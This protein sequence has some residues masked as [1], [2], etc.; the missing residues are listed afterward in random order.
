MIAEKNYVKNPL[1]TLESVV[2]QYLAYKR[3]KIGHK[4]AGL[5][6][7]NQISPDTYRTYGIR[8]A[9][10]KKYLKATHSEKIKVV[11]ID[12]PFVNAYH[13]WLN[14]QPIDAS[15][16]TKCVKL[17]TEIHQWAR[18]RGLVKTYHE[19]SFR[20]SGTP[21]TTP[22][23]VTQEEVERI[24]ALDLPP[25]QAKIRDG[26]LLARE[27][28]LHFSDFISLKPEHFSSTQ[29]GRI[30]FEKARTKQESGRNIR[31]ISFVSERALAIWNRYGQKIPIK[32]HPTHYG[33]IIAEIGMAAGLER[34]LIFSHAR[35]SGIFHLIINNCSDHQVKMAAGWTTTKQL[36]RYVNYDRRLLESLVSPGEPRILP[37]PTQPFSHIYK[38]S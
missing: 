13:A 34:K 32:R 38:A 12:T 7:E 10:L 6:S 33:R 9:W 20:G 11:K 31:Q 22:Y 28:C 1:L 26:W 27:L 8:W 35:D 18:V 36:T 19:L 16:A 24:E 23:N 15:F 17:L 3:S 2:D 14:E 30:I 25:S 21:E 5:R 37:R 29:D 4:N